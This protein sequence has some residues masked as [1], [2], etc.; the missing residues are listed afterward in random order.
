[1]R[2]DCY[3]TTMGTVGGPQINKNLETKPSELYSVIL[4]VLY[5]ISL[6]EC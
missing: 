3:I 4:S 5:G 2:V 1:M 6:H